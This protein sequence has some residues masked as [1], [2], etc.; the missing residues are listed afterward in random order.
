MRTE[1]QL[2]TRKIIV[3]LH[4]DGKSLREISKI[5]KRAVSTVKKIIDKFKKFNTLDNFKRSGRP[6]KLNKETVKDIVKEVK[7]NPRSSAVKIA[8]ICLR[9]LNLSVSA[10]TIRNT[11]HEH[12]LNGRVQR[13]KSYISKVNKKKRLAYSKTYK[14]RDFSFWKNVLFTNE[15]KFEIFGGHTNKRIWRT[16]NTEFQEKNIA[17]TVKHGGGSVMVWGCMAASGVGNLEF[18]ESTMNKYD[19]L[20]ILKQHLAPSVEKLGL[21]RVWTFQQDNDPKHTSYLAREWLLYKTPK[22]LDHPPQSPD[23]N[24]I[25]NLWNYLDQKIRQRKITSKQTLKEALKE[26]WEK[27]PEDYTKKIVESMPRRLQHVIKAKGG[28]TKY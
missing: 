26:E 17:A 21:P 11:L 25:E 27:I 4:E 9:T 8:E 20:N 2:E 5:V 24:P 7:N 18:I 23:L 22:Q 6:K 15:S 19:Y 3:N 10:D 28:Q 13:K 14:N 16:K 12:G 1:T